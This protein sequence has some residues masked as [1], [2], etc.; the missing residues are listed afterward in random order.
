MIPLIDT[1]VEPGLWVL[2][3]WSLRWAVVVGLLAVWLRVTPPRRAA[4][5]YLL[6]LVTLVAG[7]LLPL[8]PR[9]GSGLY[10]AGRPT[11]PAL[12][13][14]VRDAAPAADVSREA[15]VEPVGDCTPRLADQ[16]APVTSEVIAVGAPAPQPIGVRRWLLLG[17][18]AV[19][20]G[21]VLVALARCA[22]GW[23]F[24]ERLRWQAKPLAAAAAALFESCRVEIGLRRRAALAMHPGVGSP[25]TLGVFRPTVIVPPI[26]EELSQPVQRGAL[27]HELA[28]LVR[29]DDWL[30]A[31]LE[32]VRAA[33][34]FH[35]AVLWLL[36]R[37]E[38]ER[39]LLCDEAAVARGVEPDAYVRMLLRFA[40][41]PG[42]LLPRGLS[43]AMYPPR[44]G[45]RRTVKDRIHHLLEENMRTPNC[46]V[47]RRRLW[48]LGVLVLG[49]ALGLGSVRLAARQP[50]PAGEEPPAA[51]AEAPKAPKADD[52]AKAEYKIEPFH[53]LNIRVLGTL[54]NH[55]IAGD[56]LV[57]PEGKLDLGP[58]YGKVKV[59]GLTIDQATEAIQKH[60]MRML[61]EP[62]GVSV[63]FV[64]WVAKWQHD[65]DRQAPYRIKPNQ[66]LTIRASDL[67][68]DSPIDGPHLVELSGRVDLGP[69][70]GKV[71]VGGLTTEQAAA[72]IQKHLAKQLRENPMVSV[73]LSGWEKDWQRLEE[74]S[75]R[76]TGTSQAAKVPKDALRFG[77]K[78]FS[79]WQTE[80][81]TELKP[82][83]RI[84]GMK[85]L[86]AFGS[87]G[88]A[89][90]AIATILEIV[91]GY[92]PALNDH[93][94]QRVLRAAYQALARIGE[95]TVSAL[96]DQLKRGSPNGPRFAI[97]ALKELGPAGQAALPEL[98]A[99]LKAE[100]AFV[101]R[102]A[103]EALGKVTVRTTPENAAA[104]AQLLREKDTA[105]RQQAIRILGRFRPAS[106]A[107]IDALARALKD[108]DA[109]T[110]YQAA[111]TLA[112]YG[113]AA[114]RAV[115][116]LVEALKDEVAG[117]RRNAA[118]ALGTIKADAR[119]AVPAL[120]LAV[121]DDDISVRGAALEALGEF[122][123]EAKKAV[124]ALIKEL[125]EGLYNNR[126]QVTT[127]LQR[128]GPEAKAALP[129]LAE[130]LKQE[131]DP[132]QRRILERAMRKID[133]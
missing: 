19:W 12:A 15:V 39:E 116:A 102:Q 107:V 60:L 71:A 48:L 85:A 27:L 6:C 92:D 18:A 131:K 67:L 45:A 106:P 26:W 100:D 66:R 78:S 84:D 51:P 111:A 81:I 123:P 82:D 4:T 41:Q 57:E 125:K 127:L 74:D 52:A 108:E 29:Y 63:I 94:D 103:L 112:Q 64:G 93:D 88:Y 128:I 55:P 3:E 35:P 119:V 59:S 44:I 32:L 79:D 87:N 86:G 121:R 7:L 25:I 46:P 83:A 53:V 76:P 75:G 109:N 124:P 30:A 20:A 10:A 38:Y 50:A 96:R 1:V 49:V 24:L 91:R 97:T 77:G 23:I 40:Q 34:F 65:P 16:A 73:S 115:P 117:V 130:Y 98:L 54:V 17:L 101:Q 105:V 13:E 21:G 42:R 72:A 22:A 114:A 126:L 118:W 14:P 69:R 31:A 120:T 95:P 11:P 104:V 9:W 33:F 133:Q 62:P 90:E 99:A 47:S 28:H 80:L 129:V 68:P 113:P 8:V 43:V 58:A 2:A 110:R 132:S 70:Y 61:R 56:F 36:R 37:L 122:G 5:R 89:K